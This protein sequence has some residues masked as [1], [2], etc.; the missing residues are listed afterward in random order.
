M[1]NQRKRKI[2]IQG[3]PFK[4]ND[5]QSLNRLFLFLNKYMPI[6]F[7]RL[8]SNRHSNN[9][10]SPIIC[11]LQSESEVFDLLKNVFRLKN[12]KEFNN[13]FINPH[14]TA[15]ERIINSIKRK[16]MKC[17]LSSNKTECKGNIES[18]FVNSKSSSQVASSSK[19]TSKLNLSTNYGHNID[20]KSSSKVASSSKTT[21]KLNLSTNYGHN[22]DLK[23]QA[24]VQNSKINFNLKFYS[25][26]ESNSELDK[27]SSEFEN[28]PIIVKAGD[29]EI[30]RSDLN[31]VISGSKLNDLIINFYLKIVC[32]STEKSC[33][34][35]DSIVVS[36]ILCSKLLR[37]S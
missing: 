9:N 1:R 19:T 27:I 3:L 2:I 6:N 12:S 5:N 16:R 35:I 8:N 37:N 25:S 13:V 36:K 10:V 20:S 18:N 14:L 17:N 11:D 28:N 26:Q 23:S 30:R 24:L 34:Y 21:S 15:N 31:D 32:N 22:V 7:K 4:G 33:T 29:L